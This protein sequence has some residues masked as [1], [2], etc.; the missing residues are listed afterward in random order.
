MKYLLDHYF[1]VKFHFL[2]NHKTYNRDFFTIDTIDDGVSS[3]DIESSLL[4]HTLWMIP[5]GVARN[6]GAM[7]RFLA[8]L[9]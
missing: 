1:S 7:G 6:S 8:K 3:Y 5:S 9:F 4:T 2:K